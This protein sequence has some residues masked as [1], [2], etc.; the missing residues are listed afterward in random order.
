ME[1]NGA[2]AD[3]VF[4]SMSSTS[5]GRMS[6]EIL[7]AKYLLILGF[8]QKVADLVEAHVP[9]KRYLCATEPQY[10]EG[11]S[12]ASKQSL[13][14]QGGA[15][16][17]AEVEEWETG[18]LSQEKAKLR[19]WDDAAKVVGLEVPGVETYRGLIKF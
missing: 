19:R 8:P 12:E 11:L 15:M 7:G 1:T 13:K 18:P 10:H 3:D 14:F 2:H 9:A 5:V 17:A 6:H 16:G 4:S